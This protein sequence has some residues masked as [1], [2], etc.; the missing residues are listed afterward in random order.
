MNSPSNIVLVIGDRFLFE[1]DKA[2]RIFKAKYGNDLEDMYI[3]MPVLEQKYKDFINEIW[4][5]VK[6][7]DMSDLLGDEFIK[8]PTTEETIAKKQALLRWL[9]LGSIFNDA[10]VVDERVRI[11]VQRDPV[12]E[13]GKIVYKEWEHEN[14]YR[15]K[16]KPVKEI[17]PEVEEERLSFPYVYAVQVFDVFLEKSYHIY[18]DHEKAFCKEGQYDAE[19]AVAWLIHSDI[20]PECIE[21]ITRQGEVPNFGIKPGM[22]IKKLKEKKHWTKELYFSLLRFQA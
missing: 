11:T 4:D 10:E 6:P 9:P 14:I 20:D 15:L 17:F 16:R 19:A 13:E 3:D 2:I 5:S 12:R 7:V 18:V 8:C 22:G 21:Y 1:F